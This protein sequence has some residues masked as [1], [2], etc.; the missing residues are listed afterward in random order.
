MNFIVFKWH[1][2]SFLRILIYFRSW[3]LLFC[4]TLIIAPGISYI[5]EGESFRPCRLVARPSFR[6]APPSLRVRRP[7]FRVRPSSFRV[8]RQYRH[9]ESDCLFVYIVISDLGHTVKLPLESLITN[10][11][12]AA[13][14]P[15]STA[16][17]LLKSLI[18]TYVKAAEQQRSKV[19]LPT[20]PVKYE[21]SG[22]D[23]FSVHFNTNLLTKLPFL[24]WPA[25]PLKVG[26]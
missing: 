23:Q 22:L 16:E 7:S 3:I 9:Y 26:T 14:E 5:F 24:A 8:R 19:Q 11:V 25:S 18:T 12:K 20:K 15:I 17:L 4:Q 2:Y 21:R 13:A 1:S 10:W 6:V